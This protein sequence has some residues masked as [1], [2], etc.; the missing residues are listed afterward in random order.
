MEVGEID[1]IDTEDNGLS[2][3][4]ILPEVEDA[5][6]KAAQKTNIVEDPDNDIVDFNDI[7]DKDIDKEDIDAFEAKGSEHSS[8]SSPDKSLYLNIAKAL[9]EKGV[10]DDFEDT[11][12][13]DD[14][15]KEGSEVLME[16]LKNTVDNSVDEYK[17]QFSG[18]TRKILDAIEKGYPIND[19]LQ[20]KNTELEYGS[21]NEDTLAEA[22]SSVKQ[23]LIKDYYKKTTSFSDS[24][25]DKEVRKIFDLG[26]EDDESKYALEQLKDIS[27]KDATAKLEHSKQETINRESEFTKSMESLRDEVDNIDLSFLGGKPSKKA[28]DKYYD[29][30]TKPAGDVNGQKVNAI[31]KKR[32]DI[33]AQKF[34]IILAALMDKGVFDG[35]LSKLSAKQRRNA[36]EDLQRSVEENRGEFSKSG[37]NNFSSKSNGADS[38]FRKKR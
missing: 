25:I 8:S 18:D 23:N 16:L 20:A 19:F 38:I 35:D 26:E 4:G 21:I 37:G 11:A 1:F 30:L 27:K 36:I 10:I 13:S 5:V 15:E 3:I 22:T 31:A 2:D 6:E 29:L 24:K 14:E 32:Q 7:E 12:F 9:S 17:S 34:D 33:G 28:R